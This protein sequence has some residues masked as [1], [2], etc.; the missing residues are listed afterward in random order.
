MRVTALKLF[1]LALYLGFTL[2]MMPVQGVLLAAKAPWRASFPRWYHRVCCRILGFRREIRGTISVRRPMLFVVNHTSYTDITILGSVLEASFV[3]KAEVAR[4][5]LFGWLAKLQ[6]TV[7]VDRRAR[8]GAAQQR[9]ALAAR[10]E[11]GD[12]LVLF[13]E[14]T[15][16]DGLRVLPFKSA[17]FS[18]AECAPHGE[19]LMVQPISLTYARLDGVPIGR[20]FRPCVAWYGGMDL[21]PHLW[22][23]LGLGVIT[24]VI[25]FH[26]VVTLAEL[27]SRKALSD[28]C[29]RAVVAGVV[30][31]LTGRAPEP[32]SPPVAKAA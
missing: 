22:E 16:N 1:R 20:A 19:P 14:G 26:P 11:A 21:A 8:H 15:S 12:N 5:P 30:A 10:L 3:A 29:R 6:R 27:G 17:L 24:A 2:L 23:L 31:A 32:S 7:F 18:V 28:H 25:E 4:W 13:P 9:D